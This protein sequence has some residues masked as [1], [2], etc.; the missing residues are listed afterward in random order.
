[1]HNT[2]IV[3][4]ETNTSALPYRPRDEKLE[5]LYRRACCGSV[6]GILLWTVLLLVAIFVPIGVLFAKGQLGSNSSQRLEA[7]PLTLTSLVFPST[8]TSNAVEVS[9]STGVSTTTETVTS[10]STYSAISTETITSMVTS[11]SVSIVT[12]SGPSTFATTEA[13][14]ITDVE[15]AI[16]TVSENT[17][18]SERSVS[19]TTVEVTTTTV[20]NLPTV[21]TI[22]NTITSTGSFMVHPTTL[23]ATG[24]FVS[25]LVEVTVL[26]DEPLTFSLAPALRPTS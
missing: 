2:Y 14:T 7:A 17:S 1:M 15:T 20:L 10:V 12:Y 19:F 6:A 11:I 3:D 4:P 8:A 18:P 21:R 25:P 5:K 23:S 22:E 16:T 9:I 26:P 13:V 24:I